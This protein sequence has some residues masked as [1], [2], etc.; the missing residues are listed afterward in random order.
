MKRLKCGPMM[1]MAL[2]GSGDQDIGVEKDLH[3]SGLQDGIDSFVPNVLDHMLP[4][5][6]RSRRA[7]MN[8]EP[9]DPDQSR[10]LVNNTHKYPT[11]LGR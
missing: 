2:L 8:Q 10:V 7:A 3:R 9:I 11:R 5:R 6:F 1:R 4:V